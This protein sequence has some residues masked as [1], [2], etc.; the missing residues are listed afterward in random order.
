MKLLKVNDI[1]HLQELNFYYKFKN[2]KLPHYLQ[3]L[4]FHP[5]TQTH[6]HN[7]RTKDNIHYPIGKHAFAKNCVRFDIPRIVNNCP[8]CIIDKINTHSLQ[9]FIGYI[10]AHFLQSYQENCYIV[11]CY[12]C[13][14]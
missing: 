13:K 10:K 4:P 8:N 5:N 3:A 6:D 11:D 9:G 14:N 7:T 1:L 2:N 12:V